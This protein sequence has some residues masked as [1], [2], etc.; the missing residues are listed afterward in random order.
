M[1]SHNLKQILDLVPRT[2]FEELSKLLNK[3]VTLN[4]TFCVNMSRKNFLLKCRSMDLLPLH[5]PYRIN[6]IQN[7]HLYSPSCRFKFHKYLKTFSFTLLNLEI[8]D[9]H[10]HL[11]FL[12]KEMN[13]LKNYILSKIKDSRITNRFFEFC[14]Y[15]LVLYTNTFTEKYNNKLKTILN[16]SNSTN[17][18]DNNNNNFNNSEKCFKNLTDTYIPPDIIE[19]LS[20]GPNFNKHKLSLNRSDSVNIVKNIESK[21]RPTNIY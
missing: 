7:L 3:F 11:N 4:R 8:T 10:T 2:C 14:K 20:L 16:K 13:T 15:K 5:I 1:A 6:N 12:N 21:L 18:T 17:I 19:V 9:I